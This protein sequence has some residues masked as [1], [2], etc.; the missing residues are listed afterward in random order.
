LPRVLARVAAIAAAALM[1]AG[2]IISDHDVSAELQPQFPLTAKAY[3]DSDGEVTVFTVAG[4]AYL[5]REGDKPAT[6][7]RFFKIPEYAGYVFQFE[8][9]N[10]D[11]K[12]HKTSTMYGYFL[13]DVT[14]TGFVLH[15]WDKEATAH[16]P[17]HLNALVAIDNEGNFTVTD[18]RRDA[19]YVIR[20]LARANLPTKPTAYAAADEAK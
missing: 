12:T 6:R 9:T 7:V 3:R 17:A 14:A 4:N 19:L 8:G 5:A 18:G 20:E 2:C 15:D 10:T 13:A 16:L 11:A 1:L